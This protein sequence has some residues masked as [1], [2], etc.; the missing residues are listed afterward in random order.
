M[1]NKI[2][3]SNLVRILAIVAL[4][5][6]LLLEGLSPVSAAAAG[7]GASSYKGNNA[8]QINNPPD[9]TTM[10]SVAAGESLNLAL[11]SDGTNASLSENLSG[12]VD[13]SS[14]LTDG[15]TKRHGRK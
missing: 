5:V 9:L 10:T 15:R 2:Y 7:S 13:V 8:S 6:T 1:I 14:R 3:S 4:A 11:T 12:Q